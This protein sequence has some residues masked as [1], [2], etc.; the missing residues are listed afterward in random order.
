MIQAHIIFRRVEDDLRPLVK[1]AVQ[2]SRAVA[3]SAAKAEHDARIE[4][5]KATQAKSKPKEE[6]ETPKKPQLVSP[7]TEADKF[8][9]RLK[10]FQ[11]V[12]SSAPRR[13]NDIA[14][15]PPE[16][17]K[18]PR[19]ITSA[20]GKRDGVLSM[21]QKVMMEQ[22]REKAIVRYRALKASR[23]ENGDLGDKSEG[24]VDE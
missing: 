7:P 12:S 14:Q 16:F 9:D 15:A 18:L 8:K 3:R 21:A 24:K 10:E 23:R 5:K 17:K 11:S 6:E 22:E 19:G 2:T 13:L 1:T 20:I 4:A